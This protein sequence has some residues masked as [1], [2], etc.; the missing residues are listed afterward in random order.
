MLK[1][2]LKWIIF[3][4]HSGERKESIYDSPSNY[5]KQAVF[6]KF[7]YAVAPNAS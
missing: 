1:A 4:L 6:D 5:F 2:I 7:S 3:S